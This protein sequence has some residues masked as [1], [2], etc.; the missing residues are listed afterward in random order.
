MDHPEG[1]RP[2]AQQAKQ[3]SRRASSTTDSFHFP[4]LSSP[5]SSTDT[6]R[7]RPREGRDLAEVTE[8]GISKAI[9]SF[10]PL[11]YTKALCN[12]KSILE[13]K[14]SLYPFPVYCRPDSAL[15][16]LQILPINIANMIPAL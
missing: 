4:F 10:Y 3:H 15:S 12:M 13:E 8:L 16:K 9:E 11:S 2:R 6:Q 14:Y 1:A 7:L 5:S